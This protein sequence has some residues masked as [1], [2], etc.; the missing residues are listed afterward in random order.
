MPSDLLSSLG[1]S[2]RSQP[3]VDRDRETQLDLVAH[4]RRIAA[5]LDRRRGRVVL[6]CG[7]ARSYVPG[8]LGAWLAGATVEL[9]PNVQPGTL[10]RVDADDG[11]AY[12]LHD[13]AARQERSPKAIYVPDALANARDTTGAA[14][15]PTAWPEIAVR[16]TTSGTTER[17]KYVTKSMAQLIGEIDV[18][19][20]VFP[21]A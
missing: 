15:S 8:L 19:A 4:A 20:A 1:R 5:L 2:D 17:P 3:W 14:G 9:L 11:V 12:V 10:D 6:S 16:M 21:A 7:H 13:V 18:L